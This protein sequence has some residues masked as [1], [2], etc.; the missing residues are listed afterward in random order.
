MVDDERRKN[1]MEE[2]RK[3]MRYQPS[4]REGEGPVEGSI[5]SSEVTL[6]LHPLL[7]G[8]GPSTEQRLDE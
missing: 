2:E 3:N 5:K 1:E 6:Y 8:P 7:S 4:G